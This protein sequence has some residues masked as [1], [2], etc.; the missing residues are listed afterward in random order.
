[1]PSLVRALTPS[2][3]PA[4]CDAAEGLRFRDFLIVVLIL[5]RPARVP[6]QLDLRA[7][8]ERARRSDPE[9]QELEHG[10]RARSVGTSLG[11]EYFCDVGDAVW[12]MS[13]AS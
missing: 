11:M 5:N 7:L 1:M 6:R 10:A 4:A 9:L 12:T 2:L 3:P 8:A 13:D